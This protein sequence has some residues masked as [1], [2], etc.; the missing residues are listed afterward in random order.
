M[1]YL[2]ETHMHTVP[3]SA[4]SKSRGREYIDRYIDAGY[5][6]IIIT[7][8]F[9]RGNCGID[10]SLPWP[11]FVNQF[12]A[13]Y[14][15][16]H[17][18]GLSRNFPVFFGWEETYDGDD[19]L[20]YGLDKQWLTEHPEVTRWT[21]PQQYAEVHKY[22][23]CVVQA[24]PF[25]AAYYIHDIHL[26]P[27]FVDG[28]E[29]YNAGNNPSWNVSGLKYARL[30][31][32]PITAGSDNHH[33]EKMCHDNLAGVVFDHPLESIHDY[34]KAIRSREAFLTHIPVDV[35]EWTEAVQPE[36]PVYLM[37]KDGIEHP[38]DPILLLKNGLY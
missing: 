19:Y 33:A 10:R 30:T 35:P 38:A 29:G 28:V 36:L 3:A 9:W 12:C 26:T 22:G 5:A 20:V 8:H 13:S 34:V 23:G 16:A 11:E 1:A 17:D 32:L 2:Y 37:D 18:A 14:E 21:K 27:H 24:H 4:C 7:D 31:G 6:G 25:R 15:N